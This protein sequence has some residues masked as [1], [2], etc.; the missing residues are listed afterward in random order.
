M[1]HST[2]PTPSVRRL[3]SL[4]TIPLLLAAA[5]LSGCSSSKAETSDAGSAPMSPVAPA[6]GPSQPAPPALPPFTEEGFPEFVAGVRADAIKAGISAATV[7]RAFAGVKPI[8]RIIEL[9]RRQPEFTLTFDQYL[10]RV[11]NGDRVRAARAK[12]QENKA[13][14]DAVAERYG[15][16][17]RFIVAFW[18]IETNFGQSTGGFSV[19][20]ALAT[21]A[22][23]GRRAAYFREELMNAL[24]ILDQGHIRPAD[25]KGSWAGAM[26]QSQFMPST[27]INYAVDWNGD[28][29]R[30]IWTNRGD[31]FASAANYLK[32]SGWNDNETWGRRVTLPPGF[33]AKLAGLKRPPSESRCAALNRLTA[34][35]PL[36]EWQAMGVRRADGGDLPNQNVMAAI[37][38][39]EGPSGPAL[40][41]YGNFRATLKWNCSISFA[42]AVGTLA[43]QITAR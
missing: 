39:P 9:D 43:D 3:C 17:P 12:Y 29:K 20:S 32:Q 6:A 11:V 19:I 36:R 13:L 10:A 7:D 41:V 27:F 23:E 35:K 1:T 2:A 18:G 4:L 24:R 37:A 42:A 22:F 25:M 15:V 31:V 34:D 38:L 8:A 40:L 14:L 26:G 5:S 21:L 33:E 28:G 16:Q 30:D